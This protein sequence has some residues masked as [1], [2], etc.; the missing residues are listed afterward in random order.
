MNYNF[1]VLNA[2]KF[3]TIKK[4]IVLKIVCSNEMFFFKK[5]LHFSICLNIQNIFEN[6]NFKNAFFFAVKFQNT[7][8][9][10]VKNA[11]MEKKKMKNDSVLAKGNFYGIF[12]WSFAFQISL[13]FFFG[14]KERENVWNKKIDK[15][16]NLLLNMKFPSNCVS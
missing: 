2:S 12:I 7:L 8:F 15:R 9:S 5:V 10:F 4:K 6:F 14:K 16:K 3:V 1:F 13:S 11:A